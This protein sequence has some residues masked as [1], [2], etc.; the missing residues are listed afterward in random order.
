MKKKRQLPENSC[1]P[2]KLTTPWTASVTAENVWKEYPRPA[3][4]RDG[5][6]NL[7]GLWDYAFT[8]GPD[9]PESFDGKI[10]VPFSP[11]SSLSGVNRQLQPEEYLWYR[12]SVTVRKPEK[13][14]R[15]LLHFGAVDQRCVIYI[16]RKRVGAHSG[17]YLPF[18]LDITPFLPGTGA[19]RTDSPSVAFELLVRVQDLSDTSWQSRGKQKL[20]RGGM[21]YTAQS[22]I[23]Q[24]VW[25]EEALPSIFPQCWRFRISTAPAAAFWCR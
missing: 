20:K 18:C 8:S 1:P 10:L 5:W 25:M 23:W 14:R 2:G 4:V 11:E 21:F 17:G 7:N 9:A 3:M 22:G 12:R 15:L 13:G 16:D 19:D 6:I 24:T